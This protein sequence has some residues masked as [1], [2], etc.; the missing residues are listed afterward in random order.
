VAVAGVRTRTVGRVSMDMLAVDLGPVPDARLGSPVELW[1]DTIA[2]DEVAAAAGTIG[3]ELLCT[4]TSRV[5]REVV[6]E[7]AAPP[8]DE[9]RIR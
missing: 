7:F 3:Y 6:D 4:V 1:G 2:V 8:G 9:G 5:R